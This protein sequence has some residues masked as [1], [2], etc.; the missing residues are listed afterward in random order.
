MGLQLGRAGEPVAL[1]QLHAQRG[2][3]L[4]LGLG[5]DLFGH[6]LGRGV[7]AYGAHQLFGDFG[8]EGRHVQLDEG[9]QRQPG[10]VE[11]AQHRLVE[12]DTEAPFA[13]LVQHMGLG[14][15]QLGLV[16]GQGGHFKHH[17][18]RVHQLQ[19]A[20]AQAVVGAVDEQQAG[21]AGQGVAAGQRQGVE[22]QG[23][24]TGGGEGLACHRTVEQ[25]VGEH[26]TLFVHDGLAGNGDLGACLQVVQILEGGGH[27]GL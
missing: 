8:V 21:V 1:E 4:V 17:F 23:S 26:G 6:D 13:Q 9:R 7:A 2:H 11:L 24:V 20:A 18:V 3:T 10:G 15:D 12:G 19:V 25:L 16:A 14:L 27:S 22:Q 5:L